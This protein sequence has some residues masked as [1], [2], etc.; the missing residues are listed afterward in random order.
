MR[1]LVINPITVIYL[2]KIVKNGFWGVIIGL[3]WDFWRKKYEKIQ[4][5]YLQ[6]FTK[7][8]PH[9]SIF[10]SPT[11]FSIFRLSNPSMI[12]KSY[13]FQNFD[14]IIINIS[15]MRIDTDMRLFAK[16]PQC[17]SLRCP[18]RRGASRPSKK[19]S[20]EKSLGL[21]PPQVT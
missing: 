18:P 19:I 2:K 16:V 8:L 14:Q 11:P 17:N 5:N 10:A 7:F 6:L 13:F 4:N 3:N 20:V 15:R 1:N 21:A 9:I 12:T